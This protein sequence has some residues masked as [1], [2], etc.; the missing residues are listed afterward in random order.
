MKELVIWKGKMIMNK[1]NNFG[2]RLIILEVSKNMNNLIV[3]K[4]L[5]NKVFL[6]FF[7]ISSTN[8]VS[9]QDKTFPQ[10][11][12]VSPNAA[13]LGQYGSIPVG[14][15]TGVPNISIPIYEIELDGKKL[16]ISFSY[17]ASGIKVTQEA[18][19]VGLGWVLNAGG[20]ITKEVRGYDDFQ[21]SPI[22]Y[23]WDTDLPAPDSN[24]DK[25]STVSWTVFSL[26]ANNARDG[27]PDLFHYNF[28]GFSGTCFFKKMGSD[29]NT[30]TLAVPVLR[31]GKDFI[32]IQYVIKGG[33]NQ[34]N[35]YWIATDLEGFKY[36][37][38]TNER[39]HSYVA[40]AN[41][42][43]KRYAYNPIQSYVYSASYLDSIVAPSGKKIS[44]SYEKD[45]IYTHTKYSE[46]CYRLVNLESECYSNQGGLINTKQYSYPYSYS[47]N[48]QVLLSKIIFPSGEITINYNE[49]DDIESVYSLQKARKIDNIVIKNDH[50]A[51]IKTVKLKHSYMGKTSLSATQKRL[52]LDTLTINDEAYVFSYYNKL[53]GLP[54]KDIEHAD[55]WG[56]YN[57]TK[58]SNKTTFRLAPSILFYYNGDP[59]YYSGKDNNSREDYMKIGTLTSMQYPS[60]GYSSFTYEMH[61]FSNSN[62]VYSAK[63]WIIGSHSM[64]Y[65]DLNDGADSEFEEFGDDF[66][67]TDE[68][69]N[70]K[71]KISYYHYQ[72][73]DYYGDVTI[74][75]YIEIQK[76]TLTGYLKIKSGDV[77][78]KCLPDESNMQEMSIPV[79]FPSTGTYRIRISTDALPYKI[80]DT[81]TLYVNPD[82]DVDIFCPKVEKIKQGGG[83]RIKSITNYANPDKYS[84]RIFSYK[85]NGISTGLLMN[86][87]DNII[88]FSNSYVTLVDRDGFFKLSKTCS[89]SIFG[90]IAASSSWTPFTY[91]A[92][93]QSVGYSYV[94]ERIETK[95]G[96]NGKTTFRFSNKVDREI[97]V[98]DRLIRGYPSIPYLNNGNLIETAYYDDSDNIVKKENYTYTKLFSDSIKGLMSF[99]PNISSTGWVA[100][101]YYDLYAERWMLKEKIDTLFY[102]NNYLVNT[103]KY[104]Y[105]DSTWLVNSTKT[106]NSLNELIENK[107]TYPTDIAN[108]IYSNMVKLNML[109]FPIEKTRKVNDNTTQSILTTYKSDNNTYVKDKVYTL[110]TDTPLSSFTEFNGT[111][112]DDNY[113]NN[114]EVE[115]VKYDAYSNPT[116][117]KSKSGIYTYYVWA[118]NHQYPVAK[119][120][121]SIDANISVTVEDS[122]LSGSDDLAKIKTDVAYLKGKLSGYIGKKDYMVSYYTYKPLV[123][124][125]SETDPAGHTTYY[126]YDDFGR[127]ELARDQDGNIVKKYKYNYA[128]Q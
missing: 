104:Q 101:K 27:E 106:Y 110:E 90:L 99:E 50:D 105:D 19:T 115:F 43:R 123:G 124:M 53:A 45:Y 108:G 24:N 79:T 63:E 118:Y 69:L 59:Y 126:E 64:S 41:I 16:P 49:R 34:V 67:V 39:T 22:G 23:Y 92:S 35:D 97:D 62:Y 46:Y 78:I 36:Y 42:D 91:S 103:K 87:V 65:D 111:K 58:A 125:T 114:P 85:K 95:E 57:N 116:K 71:M 31:D 112:K 33:A 6:I 15:Y 5:I 81:R 29:G 7:L 73:T 113:S 83:L 75:A 25:D 38:Q 76:K 14:Y 93:G 2:D 109:S 28:S 9:G 3:Y 100:L 117:L 70:G 66:E 88:F 54:E 37:F 17:H 89:F 121:S 11:V 86:K 82:I 51:V 44:F 74:D 128:E 40:A 84:K 1:I 80:S 52:M 96:N 60:G 119:I 56:Y 12:P 20:C 102:D 18:S 94:E 98:H 120:E 4:N 26:Y 68:E 107:I 77:D 48:E 55:Y 127:L 72:P 21:K 30:K 122:R 61:D 10:I 8:I 32:K 13:A 47:Q